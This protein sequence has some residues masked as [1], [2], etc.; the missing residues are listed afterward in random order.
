MHLLATLLALAQTPGVSDSSIVVGQPAVFSGPSAGLGVELWRGMSAALREANDAGGVHGRKVNVEMC[1]DKYDPDGAASCALDL[2]KKR[3]VLLLA[4]TVGTPT[5][6]KIIPFLQAWAKDNVYLFGNFTGAQPQRSM[7][8]APYVFNVRASYHQETAAHVKSCL[9]SGFNKIGTYVQ[10]DAFGKDGEE[11]VRLALASK[12]LEIAAKT[13][14][15]RGTKYDADVAQQV[16]MLRDAGVTCV[17]TTGSYQGVGA[18]IRIARAQGWN[19]PIFGV[20]FTGADQLLQLLKGTGGNVMQ[21]VVMTQV[22]PHP[23]D[24]SLPLVKAYRA[25]M[26]KYDPKLPPAPFDQGG[27]APTGRYSFGSLEGY[28]NTRL[29]LEVFTRAGKELTRPKV[30]EAAESIKNFDIGLGPGNV[31]TWGPVTSSEDRYNHQA[32][33]TVWFTVIKGDK[34]VSVTESALKGHIE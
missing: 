11:G 1:D 4:N 21:H 34:W 2:V 31:I 28:L 25:A 33:N 10:N 3:N 29:L 20:S 30:K 8:H 27:Y 24:A 12:K 22:V 9:A 7:P 18:F 13:Y 16:K 23:D 32:L 5:I 15:E 14:Y 19:V 17:S 6:V 26:E